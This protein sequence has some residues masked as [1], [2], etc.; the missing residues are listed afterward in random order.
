MSSYCNVVTSAYAKNAAR[1]SK[2]NAQFAMEKLQLSYQFSCHRPHVQLA[3]F[4]PS[5]EVPLLC[6]YSQHTLLGH[7]SRGCHHPVVFVTTVDFPQKV[8]FSILSILKLDL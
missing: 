5:L 7:P 1:K 4:N 8:V 3:L 2:I 6:E